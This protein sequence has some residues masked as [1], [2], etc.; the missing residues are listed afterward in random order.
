MGMTED[1]M[2][3]AYFGSRIVPSKACERK[4]GP[5]QSAEITD[6]AC[7][8]LGVPLRKGFGNSVAAKELK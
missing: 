6:E 8:G 1:K 4:D 2:C 5:F 7:F 3:G